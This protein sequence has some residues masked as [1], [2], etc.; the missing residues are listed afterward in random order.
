MSN[1]TVRWQ[2]DPEKIRI[3]IIKVANTTIYRLAKTYWVAT[4]T[5]R[6]SENKV[7]YK[8]G[9]PNAAI[10]GALQ[11]AEDAGFPV[12]LDMQWAYEHPWK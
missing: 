2:A 12:D 11:N 8:H 10:A 5:D 9:N 4:V 1:N 6:R 3:S 7:S